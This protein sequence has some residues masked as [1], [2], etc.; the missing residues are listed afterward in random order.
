MEQVSCPLCGADENAFLWSKADARYVRC[1]KCALVFENPRLTEE[2]LKTFY[3][4][5][6]YFIHAGGEE[7]VSGYVDYFAQCS[8]Q[9]Q[10]EYF[11]IVEQCAGVPRGTYLDIGCGT[12]GVIGYARDKGWEALGQEISSWASSVG[13]K[14]G[15]NI[16]DKPLAE[17]ELADE[18]F[19]AV[20]MFDVLEHLPQPKEYLREIFRILKPGGVLVVETPNIDGLFARYL[21]KERSELVK[22]RAHICLYGPRSAHRLFST[23]PFHDVRIQTFPYCRRFTPGYFKGLVLSFVLP[24][25]VPQ[26][27]TLNESLR[28]ICRK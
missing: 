1:R 26:Q 28:I 12:G 21:Y 2:E 9:L 18:A 15:L 23:V 25:R 4:D 7:P 16:I 27:L 13:K 19:D 8:P 17:A 24:G 14:S 3:S 11:R 10:E 5:K 22:P 6:S 20:S